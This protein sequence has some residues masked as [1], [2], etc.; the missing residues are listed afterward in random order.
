MTNVKINSFILFY[1]SPS[2]AS[3]FRRTVDINGPNVI[4]SIHH[5]IANVWKFILFIFSFFPSNTITSHVNCLDIYIYRDAHTCVIIL[6]SFCA[7]ILYFS[8]GFRSV[9]FA[10]FHYGKFDYKT[11]FDTVIHRIF[12]AYIPT[13]SP[14]V[15]QFRTACARY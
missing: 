13:K 3:R 6:S 15:N 7:L 4:I 8:C 1:P 9:E 14:D 11:V 5:D 12:Y 10:S 2:S